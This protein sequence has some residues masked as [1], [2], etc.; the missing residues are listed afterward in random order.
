RQDVA[1]GFLGGEVR[2]TEEENDHQPQRREREPG[3]DHGRQRTTWS[4]RVH[5]LGR[6]RS[7]VQVEG[8]AQRRPRPATNS[9]S[10]AGGDAAELPVRRLRGLSE[11]ALVERVE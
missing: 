1:P 10:A 4:A 3:P 2:A 11:M 6:R 5:A 8:G 9:G 7:A